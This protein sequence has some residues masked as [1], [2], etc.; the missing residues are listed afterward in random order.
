MQSFK[1]TGSSVFRRA[2]FVDKG[3]NFGPMVALRLLLLILMALQCGLTSC[4]KIKNRVRSITKDAIDKVHPV[5]DATTPD[6]KYNKERFKEFFRVPLS[7]DVKDIYCNAEWF[8]QDATYQFAFS[9][10]KHTAQQI[11][12][13]NHFARPDAQS[14]TYSF[15]SR[16]E[17]DWW[18]QKK[19]DSLPLLVRHQDDLFR[20]FW[21]DSIRG[22]AYYL[23]FDI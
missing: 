21:Y 22:K 3:D 18:Q 1:N 12:N 16:I 6:T 10:N 14:G 13:V 8:G 23:D 11:I 15:S 19:I 20:Y 7:P 5:F 4:S 2:F 17:F 9:C